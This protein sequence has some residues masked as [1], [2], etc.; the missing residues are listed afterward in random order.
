MKTRNSDK[1]TKALAKL[2]IDTKGRG[3]RWLGGLSRTGFIRE[4]SMG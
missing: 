1:F 2:L 3:L 4:K